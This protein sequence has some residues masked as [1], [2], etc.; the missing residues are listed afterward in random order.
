MLA[1]G[2]RIEQEIRKEI[3]QP[4]VVPEPAARMV[5]GIDGALVRAGHTDEDQ[6]L[7]SL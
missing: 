7:T 5:V 2:R 1:V 4:L 3:D 6:K